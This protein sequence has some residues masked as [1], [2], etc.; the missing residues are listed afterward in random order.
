MR[1]GKGR[2]FVTERRKV[3][4]Y[5]G[6]PLQFH[7]KHMLDSFNAIRDIAFSSILLLA[8]SIC[9]LFAQ[10]AGIPRDTSF[11]INN[12]VS[13]V[14]KQYPY[15]KLVDAKLPS[16]VMVHENIVYARYGERRLH[17]DLFSPRARREELSP[18]VILIH[19]GGW[20]SGNRQMEWP[21][22]EFLAAHG[23]ITA[24]VE[25]RLSVEALYPAGVYDV[26]G[27]I[28]WMRAHAA[29]HK[30]D[31]NRIA[32]YGCSSGGEL[33]AFLGTTGDVKR[34]EG[35]AGHAGTSGAVQAVVDIDGVL[36]FT[37]PAESA[38]DSDPSKPSAGKAWFGAS[39]KENPEIWRDAS[40]INYV[41]SKTAPILFVN[42]S[43][44]RFHA[45][46][47]EVIAQLN[48]LGIYSEVHTIPD[49]PHPFW[50]FHPWF[51]EA[52]GT[53]VKF[54]DKTLKNK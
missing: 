28:R 52:S 40:P 4:A 26:K 37:T 12:T 3:T 8:I 24:T 38:K 53:I 47:D 9:S 23:Y 46:R 7:P 13:K 1:I 50:L 6:F 15:A 18:G 49:T 31:P 41:S 44:D 17:L 35:N 42:S 30:I 20:R 36:D 16:G 48:K 27:A 11:T 5:S 32:V 21:M 19:G 2:A 54:L 33:A 34:F 22:A 43:L 45:G 25:Y 51:D 39:Y 10:R 29:Q 14:T